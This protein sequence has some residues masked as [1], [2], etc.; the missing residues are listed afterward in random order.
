MEQALAK[1]SAVA[2]SAVVSVA[3][4]I[5]GEL[6]KAFVVLRPGM[7]CSEEELIAHCKREL[8]A[9][10]VPKSIEF[11]EALPVTSTGKILRRA[12]RG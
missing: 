9:Y 1:H 4:E 12:L 5:K 8:A 10:K 6:A 11:I 7:G 2:I 3:D